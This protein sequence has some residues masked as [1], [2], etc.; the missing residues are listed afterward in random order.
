M[1]I[2]YWTLCLLEKN[3]ILRRSSSSNFK[4]RHRRV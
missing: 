3:H 1:S 4:K 2:I